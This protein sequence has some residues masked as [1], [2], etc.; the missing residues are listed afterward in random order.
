MPKQ[1]VIIVG[2]GLAGLTAAWELDQAGYEV[3]VIEAQRPPG[4]RVLTLREG[5]TPGISAEAGA[6]S[7]SDSYR[8]LL[9][10]A[11]LFQIP[12]QP[13][14]T[15]AVRS[16]GQSDLYHLRGKRIRAGADGMVDW[17]FDLTP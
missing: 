8:N 17:S 7:F 2:A 6:M 1:K 16:A 13:L 12:Y 11:R 9:Y 3:V 15:A 10:Y 5:F 4:G 14:A